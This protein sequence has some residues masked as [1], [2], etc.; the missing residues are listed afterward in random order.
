[1]RIAVRP[2]NTAKKTPVGEYFAGNPGRNPRLKLQV[3]RSPS[4][5]GFTKVKI[6]TADSTRMASER[7]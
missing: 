5:E 1:M 7:N 4:Y 2:E 6:R 3:I